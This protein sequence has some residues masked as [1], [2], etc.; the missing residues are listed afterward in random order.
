MANDGVQQGC[1]IAGACPGPVG[2]TPPGT[3]PFL[4]HHFL[5]LFFLF[6]FLFLLF[7]PSIPSMPHI[8]PSPLSLR[9]L[10]LSGLR[11]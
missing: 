1:A 3:N 7:H 4:F 9:H 6:L 2:S 10:H 11:H 5:P 8:P